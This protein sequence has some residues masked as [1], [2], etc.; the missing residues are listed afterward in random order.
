MTARELIESLRST[1]VNLDQE[2]MVSISDDSDDS[3]TDAP[4]SSVY[5]QAGYV[6]LSSDAD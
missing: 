5:E 2:V 1:V 4:L 6:F 3:P